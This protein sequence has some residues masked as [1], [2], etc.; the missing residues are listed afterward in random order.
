M[1]NLPQESKS[2]GDHPD[3]AYAPKMKEAYDV[4]YTRGARLNKPQRIPA[5][6]EGQEIV[7]LVEA[8]SGGVYAKSAGATSLGGGYSW[9]VSAK[10]FLDGRYEE[11]CQCGR[12]ASSKAACKHLMRV[13]MA[14]DK[15]S[16]ATAD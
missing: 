6:W 4:A 8:F 11:A 16:K 9:R 1:K 12:N 13:L 7:Y 10:A 15:V 14:L 5:G 3:D 2:R